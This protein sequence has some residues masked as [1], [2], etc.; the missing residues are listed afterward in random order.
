M[1]NHQKQK[2]INL[3]HSQQDRA[4]ERR[5]N[6]LIMRQ[7]EKLARQIHFERIRQ[8]WQQK[9]DYYVMAKLTFGISWFLANVSLVISALR[10][11]K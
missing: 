11:L 3:H 9:V 7:N 1:S 6:E 8:E 10:F 2:A 5:D 4:K